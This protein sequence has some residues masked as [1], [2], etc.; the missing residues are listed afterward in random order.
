MKKMLRLIT[1]KNVMSGKSR[2]FVPECD[3]PRVHAVSYCAEYHGVPG[4]LA[5]LTPQN[6]RFSE[7][8]WFFN[9]AQ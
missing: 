9:C 1:N 4:W 8:P 3:L 6:L 5:V 2:V 7:I